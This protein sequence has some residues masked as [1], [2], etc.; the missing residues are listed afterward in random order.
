MATEGVLAERVVMGAGEALRVEVASTGAVDHNSQLVY[1]QD[2]AM[3]NSE[4][5]GMEK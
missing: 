5:I 4:E 1:A 2:G 3:G